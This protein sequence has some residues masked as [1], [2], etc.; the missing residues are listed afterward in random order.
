VKKI[1]DPIKTV[2]QHYCHV[3]CYE[4]HELP[5][6]MKKPSWKIDTSIFRA[7]LDEMIKNPGEYVDGVNEV[8]GNEFQDGVELKVWLNNIWEQVFS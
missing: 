1:V 6:D 2:F 7:Q 4:V 3:E 8:T 5:E